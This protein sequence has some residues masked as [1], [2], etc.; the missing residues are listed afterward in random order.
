LLKNNGSL[1]TTHRDNQVNYI[2]LVKNRY[3]FARTF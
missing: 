2:T 1:K 3:S